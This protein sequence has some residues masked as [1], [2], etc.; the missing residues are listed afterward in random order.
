MNLKAFLLILFPVF[1]LSC[2]PN[3]HLIYCKNKQRKMC[4]NL[5]TFCKENGLVC[6]TKWSMLKDLNYDKLI[7][8]CEKKRKFCKIEKCKPTLSP[9]Y[10]PS[11]PSSISPSNSPSTTYS[12][13]PTKNPSLSPSI[14]PSTT[15]SNSHTK[16]PLVSPSKKPTKNQTSNRKYYS[17]FSLVLIPIALIAIFVPNPNLIERIF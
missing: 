10:M 14:Y 11:V 15:P 1:S 8:P 5:D 16:S 9:T 6:R 12:S 13:S 17:M 4:V 7:R 3:E 2:E